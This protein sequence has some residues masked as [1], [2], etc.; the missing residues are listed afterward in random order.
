MKV[1]EIV[2]EVITL[3]KAANQARIAGGLE[4]DSP[5]IAS[6]SYTATVKPR[7]A[8]ERQL[9]AFLEAQTPQ[10]IYLLMAIMYLGRG[11]FAAEELTDQW[12]EVSETFVNAKL[13]ARQMFGQLTLPVFLEKGVAKLKL[14]GI[15]VDKLAGI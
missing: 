15:D 12:A 13:A 11:D 1:S 7:L 8:E 10:V 3:A 5:L 4:D 14:A 9:R 2:S 6:G